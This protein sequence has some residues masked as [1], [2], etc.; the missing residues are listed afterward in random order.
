[1]VV[2]AAN[3]PPEFERGCIWRHPQFGVQ[4]LGTL[5]VLAQG[6]GLLAS[7][8]IQL[9]QMAVNGFVGRVEPQLLQGM[10][11]GSSVLTADG[12]A[13]AQ[14]GECGHTFAA[15]RCRLLALPLVKIRRVRQAE[16]GQ[17]VVLVERHGFGEG[18]QAAGADTIGSM[19][20]GAA[21]GDERVQVID[22]CPDIG[23]AGQRDSIAVRFDPAWTDSMPQ[24][25][26]GTPK[27]TTSFGLAVIGPEQR[28][29]R[30]A[31]VDVA[32]DGQVNKQRQRLAP[33]HGYLV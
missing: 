10:G 9:H 5:G 4:R 27:M 7:V 13:V 2:T 14:P 6:G 8:G 25:I 24:G 20:V 32:R 12:A 17:K 16:T 1:M 21:A 31:C 29:Q 11:D 22:I 23:V 3:L 26:K 33:W 28:G 30:V 18:R 15:Q 19:A